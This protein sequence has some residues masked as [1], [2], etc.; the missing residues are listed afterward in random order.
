MPDE[1]SEMEMV[2]AGERPSFASGSVC[3]P[4]LAAS[5]TGFRKPK[6]EQVLNYGRSGGA[7]FL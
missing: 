7:V 5:G 3:L 2:L 4:G 1:K 6:G